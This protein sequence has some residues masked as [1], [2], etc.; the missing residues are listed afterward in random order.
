MPVI[1]A[2]DEDKILGFATYGIFRPKIAYRFS[3]EHSI[4]LTP[5]ARGK[6][7]GTRLLQELIQIAKT[8]GYHTMIAGVDTSNAVSYAFHKNLG[9]VE[10]ARFKEVGFKFDKW[11]DL[12]FM[13]LML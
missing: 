8:G 7:V 10:V 4:Y 3:V 9:F 6:G 1:I 13:Q 5:D 2:V 12:V 11:L